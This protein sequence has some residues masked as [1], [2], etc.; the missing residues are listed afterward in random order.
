M[1]ERSADGEE[2]G[3][4]RA[5]G[6]STQF[7]AFVLI[8]AAALCVFILS[9]GMLIVSLVKTALGADWA[10]RQMWPHSIGV[11][12]IL[13]A[14]IGAK[15]GNVRS[16]V[17]TYLLMCAGVVGFMLF[18]HLALEKKFPELFW[19]YFF[20]PDAATNSVPRRKHV[21]RK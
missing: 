20:P 9:P 8:L 2:G 7:W 4:K 3:E 18:A 6:N 11:S 17:R 1:K 21:P 10:P 15:A 12:V 13:G 19:S 16:A 14:I 5:G